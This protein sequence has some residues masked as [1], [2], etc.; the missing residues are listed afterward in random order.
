M[1]SRGFDPLGVVV[2]GA[3]A[4]AAVIGLLALPDDDP[5]VPAVP[6]VASEE[7]AAT[8][9][10]LPGGRLLER[11]R[12]PLDPPAGRPAVPRTDPAENPHV[13]PSARITPDYVS[14]VV[15]DQQVVLADVALPWRYW[16][17]SQVP[18]RVDEATVHQAVAAWDGLPG[19]RWA[20]EFAGYRP[21]AGA[22]ADGHST[23]FMEADCADL[24]TANAYLFT[25]GGLGVSRY[26]TAATQILE[27]DIGICPRVVDS[28]QLVRAVTHEVGHVVGLA[29]LCDPDDACWHPAMGEGPHVCTVMFWQARSCQAELST[30]DRAAVTA[31]YP[32][33]RRLSGPDAA[34]ATARTSFALLPDGSATVGVVVASHSPPAVAAAGAALAGRTAGPY[35]VGAPVDDRCL[36]G[37]TSREAARVLTRR[38]TLVLVGDWPEGCDDLAYD[39][40]IS[41][42]RVAAEDPAAAAVALADLGGSSTGAVMAGAEAPPEELL[43]AAVLAARRGQPLLITPQE[44]VPGV[45]AEHLQAVGATAL[46][47]VGGTSSVGSAVQADLPVLGVDRV[48][49]GDPLGTALAVA[50]VVR[51]GGAEGVVLVAAPGID[52]LAGVSLAARDGAVVLPAPSAAVEGRIEQWLMA[53]GAPRG[54]ALGDEDQLPPATLAAYAALVGT[55]R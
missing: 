49:G 10:A 41:V 7:P 1:G 53:A 40:D 50:D 17:D 48:D 15:F 16:V 13:V 32:T 44:T 21:S 36:H 38:A 6:S 22:V 20:A 43:A 26:G 24:T 25:D 30:G 28:A 35:L 19:S 8:T 46:T 55:D 14:G 51:A 18:D 42:R 27:A 12:D 34:D 3:F 2:V 5:G 4:L 47:I 39:W 31:L 54:W 9:Q 33:L 23:I 29:H 52:G 37:S 11:Q 45:V